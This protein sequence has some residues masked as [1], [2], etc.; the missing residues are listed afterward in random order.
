V[1]GGSEF[2]GDG[3]HFLVAVLADT[4][5]GLKGLLGGHAVAL[6]QDPFGLADQVA[7][8]DR[9]FQ[10]VQM[11]GVGERDGGVTGEQ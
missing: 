1:S 4:G 9:F 3:S 6:H 7:S 2:L 8:G 5:E 10:L 11:L